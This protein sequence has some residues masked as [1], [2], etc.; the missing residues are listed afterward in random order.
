MKTEPAK[1]WSG[2]TDKETF[3]RI[4]DMDSVS[5]MWK[6]CAEEYGENIAVTDN[7]NTYSYS[8]LDKD[9]AKFRTHF[10]GM[11]KGERI[12]ILVP[13]S[14]EFIRAYLAVTTLGLTAVI[15]PCGLPEEAVG[16]CCM[17]FGVKKLVYSP[18]LSKDTGKIT[19]VAPALLLINAEDLPER[20]A[21]AADVSAGDPC[22]IMFTGGTTGRSKGVQLGN[23]AVMQGTVNGCYGYK[24]VFEQRYLLVLPLSHVF[25]LIRNLMTSL[26]TGSNL[27][28]C[29]DNK[30]MFRDCA[31]FQPT[32]LVMVPA[33]V[34]MA[35]NLSAR[36]GRNMLGDKI[37]T[38]ICGAAPVAPYLV[39]ECHKKG[40]ALLP[41]YGLTESANLV[42]GNPDSINHS[43]SVGLMFPNQE[44][45]IQDGELWLRGRNMLDG[46]IGEADEEA[47]TDGWFRT[48]DLARVDEDGFLYI[49][50][51]IKEVIVLQSGENV[52]PAEVEAHFNALD[53]VQDT[54]VFED[55]NDQGK[56]ILALEVL[57]RM[58]VLASRG[59]EDVKAYMMQELE[60]VNR[61]LPGYCRVSRIV[62]REQD[63][64]RS[65]SMKIVRYKK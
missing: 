1:I 57:P 54:Q 17:K 47:Y 4:R 11:K 34:E 46:Y 15:I 51:R 61:S 14:Y 8:E 37:R 26:Y 32:M 9:A 41:G 45:L 2:Y 55:V 6:M 21:P 44:Y 42:S 35:L 12:G 38:I 31:V 49:T 5:E 40:I 3:E 23:A 16:G 27:F 24:E 7:G 48:G 58:S 59:I 65:P 39:E 62:I 19:K 56:Q 43:D 36:F 18:G 25:G 10:A 33:L 64:E 50:G 60:K 30:D 52:S 20:S 13:N 29:R 63:F 53:L 28:I 22:V